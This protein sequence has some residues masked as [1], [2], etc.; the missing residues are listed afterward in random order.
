MS[1]IPFTCSEEYKKRVVQLGENPDNVFNV[2]ALGVENIQNLPLLDKHQVYEYLDIEAS[3]RFFLITFHPATL[4]GSKNKRDFYQLLSALGNECFKSFGLIFTKANADS[5][6]KQINDMA[7]QFVKENSERAR[8]FASMG[9]VNYLSVVKY[10]AAVVGN[11]SSGIIEAPCFSVPVINIG[12]RQA[13]RVKADNIID[14]PPAS[15]EIVESLKKGLSKEFMASIAG[16]SCPFEK[17]GTSGKIKRILKEIELG[18][19]IFKSFSDL[20]FSL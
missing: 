15:E 7:A 20:E 9:Q 6:G 2:G 17:H 10:S 16:T 12:D 18:D 5:Y 4:H 13:G 14:C 11:S 1:H 3:C 8:I 19:I